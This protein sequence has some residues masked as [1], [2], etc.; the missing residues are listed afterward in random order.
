MATVASVAGYGDK[1]DFRNDHDYSAIMIF[2]NIA[3]ERRSL[4]D[5]I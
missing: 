1:A 5:G 4:P 3:V 2:S